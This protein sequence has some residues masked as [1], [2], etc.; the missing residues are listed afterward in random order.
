MLD[1]ILILTALGSWL[2][3][4]LLGL[5]NTSD[6]RPH[7]CMG[8]LGALLALVGAAHVLWT[9][10][11]SALDFTLWKMT[12]RI[13][14]DALSA[15]FLLPLN[16]V[17]GL[18]VVYA[19]A[20]WPLATHK[21]TGRSVRFF[22]ALL[23]AALMLVF[24]A[25]HG[26]LF[27]MAWE[28]MA[29]AAFFLVGTE[30]EKPQVQRAS[31]IYLMC[32]HTG[33]LFLFAVMA[34]LALRNGTFLWVPPAGHGASSLDGVILAI[35]LLGFGFKAG[36]F[37]LHF[38]LPEAHAWA[39]SHVSAILSGV[40]LKAGIYGII[41]VSGLLPSTPVFLG[42]F[43]LTLGA[44]TAIYG[45]IHA[46]AQSDTKRLLAYSSIENIGIIGIGLGLGWT[47]RATHE[48]WLAALGFGGAIFHVW[49][50]SIF[51]ALLFLGAGSLL[52]A[53]RTRKIEA[54][55]G[56]AARMPRTTL[57]LFPAV[58]AVAALPPFSAFLSEWFLYRG[59]FGSF[60]GSTSWAACFAL[61]ALALT[62]GLAAV[63]FAKFFGFVFL[64][65]PR[66]SAA[67]H[68]RDPGRAMLT[69]M[70]ILAMLCLGMGLGGVLLLPVLD[71]VVAVVAPEAVDLLLPG[72][73]GDLSYLSGMLALL[74]LLGTIAYLWLHA[75]R[76]KTE[77]TKLKE[78]VPTWDCGYLQPTVR[79]QYTGSSFSETWAALV[80]GFSIQIR[81]I[82]GLF[83]KPTS[84][85]TEIQDVVG[86]GV[87]EQ[88]TERLAGRMLRFRQLQHGHLS[89]Y[90][91][92][93]LLALLGV[94]L[95]MLI[96]PR[97]LG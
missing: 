87:V 71:R 92:Y 73:H 96:R 81:R 88:Q 42:G 16:L 6:E 4:S 79:M 35:A 18:G 52:H 30:H 60:R 85:H 41:R 12:A 32:T 63:A 11:P 89:V 39:P 76:D 34:L 78:R 23:A 22:Y 83:P 3:A 69:P 67:E 48:P 68:A 46:L 43:V 36:F 80:P 51:K 54:L 50:H 57:L 74:L 70:A 33:T 25:R 10:T 97:L 61:P 64:G 26:I 40:M 45:V 95:W 49:N 65:E 59:L 55:G 86:E 8:L 2:I 31:W 20:Y 84:F 44:V 90:V 82:R 17:A 21:A 93:I 94:F 19:S 72:L 9:G 91:L 28:I 77:E 66:S 62:G 15:A 47:G 1:I 14:V 13:E 24:I 29:L 75:S 27:L 56:L 37:P 58:L 7:L 38:W 5:L 53:T